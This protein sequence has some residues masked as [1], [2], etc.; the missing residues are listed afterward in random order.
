MRLILLFSFFFTACSFLETN[1]TPT[2][3]PVKVLGVVDPKMSVVKLYP[4]DAY[5]E[6]QRFFLE[7]RNSSGIKVDVEDQEI[8]VKCSKI[9][10][11]YKVLWV[12]QGR[13]QLEF[14]EELEN[15]KKVK[16]LVQGK[17]L[18]HELM[19][20]KKPS[21]SHSKLILLGKGDHQIS[22]KLTLQNKRGERVETQAPPEIILE[23]LGEVSTLKLS[24]NGIWEFTVNLPELNQI[25]YL[26][27]RANGVEF[28]HLFRY[29]HIEK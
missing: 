18:K 2:P 22:M 28:D 10:P 26:N 16:F 7:L 12:S 15:L 5:H 29:Q 3:R 13:Y 8:K 23:G 27:V 25:I 21:R 6:G 11:K 19:S 1:S 14:A 24:Q 9:S 20:F 4:P 17:L